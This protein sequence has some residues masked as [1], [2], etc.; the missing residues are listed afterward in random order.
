MKD[1]PDPTFHRDREKQFFEHA[2]HLLD[3]ERLRIDTKAGRRPVTSGFTYKSEG[4]KGVERGERAKRLMMELGVAD[5]E[6]QHKLPVGERLDV[7]LKMRNFWM[8][9]KTVGELTIA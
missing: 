5:R 8:L 2:R 4:E 9:K 1:S 7:T 3:D 6:L